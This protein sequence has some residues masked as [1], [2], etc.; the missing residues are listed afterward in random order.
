MGG[1]NKNLSGTNSLVKRG[2]TDRDNEL[3][4]STLKIDNVVKLSKI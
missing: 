1:L 2:K 3:I 4:Q